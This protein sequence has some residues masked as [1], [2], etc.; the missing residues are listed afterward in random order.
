MAVQ[1]LTLNL[2]ETL[3]HRLRERAGQAN[4]TVEDETLDV[5]ATAV[6]GAEGQLPADLEEAVAQLTLLTDQDLWRAARGG[7]APDATARLEDLHLKR[8]REG[9]TAAEGQALSVLVRQYERS[10]LVRARAAALL[11]QRGHD[12][13]GLLTPP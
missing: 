12:V 2:P 13:T 3:Y 10:M 7:L 8:Q 4:R 6:S 9:L 1:T 11:R 5:L